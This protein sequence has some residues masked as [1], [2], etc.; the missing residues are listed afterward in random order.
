[1][2]EIKYLSPSSISTFFD[3]RTEFYLKYCAENRPP[4]M[5]QTQPM[6]VGSAFDAFVKNHLVYSLHDTVSPSFY[7]LSPALP[8]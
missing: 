5:K 1:M 2:R 8:S 4:R 7:G 3:D 6:S